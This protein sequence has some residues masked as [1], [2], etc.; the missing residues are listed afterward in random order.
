MTH[1]VLTGMLIVTVMTGTTATLMVDLA[2]AQQLTLTV[3]V[4]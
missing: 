4:P 1:R 3:N 2:I